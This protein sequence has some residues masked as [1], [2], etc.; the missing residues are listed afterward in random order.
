MEENGFESCRDDEG[1]IIAILL[2]FPFLPFLA[3]PSDKKL[4][5]LE[6]YFIYFYFHF[7]NRFFLGLSFFFFK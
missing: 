4:L 5:L 6:F 1:T 7:R 2:L 3:L